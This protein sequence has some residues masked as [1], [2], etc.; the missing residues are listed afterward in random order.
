MTAKIMLRMSC[1]SRTYRCASSPSA[2]PRKSPPKP[3]RQKHPAPLPPHNNASRPPLRCASGIAS[4]AHN[5][6]PCKPLKA[7]LT[8]LRTCPT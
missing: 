7:K 6:R 3:R 8:R 2:L 5:E 4:V 1:G